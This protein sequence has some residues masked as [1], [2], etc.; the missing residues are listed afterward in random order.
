[1]PDEL[2]AQAVERIHRG[3][4]DPHAPRSYWEL[5][6][7][8]RSGTTHL[9]VDGAGSIGNTRLHLAGRHLAHLRKIDPDYHPEVR[10]FS[11]Y[12]KTGRRGYVGED[13]FA[14]LE[15]HVQH[16][17]AVLSAR[18]FTGRWVITAYSLGTAVVVRPRQL[19]HPTSNRMGA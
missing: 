10:A 3:R 19:R 2:V 11:Y 18:S 4:G 16:L 13:T 7:Y 17:A 6:A 9:F 1:M 5:A 12:A 15:E 8:P 14:T